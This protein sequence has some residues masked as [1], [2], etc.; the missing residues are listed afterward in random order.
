MSNRTR[1]RPCYQ[2]IPITFPSGSVQELS[3]EYSQ[4]FP[5]TRGRQ[6][7][8]RPLGTFAPERVQRHDF[9]ISSLL[10]SESN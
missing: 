8:S 2:E 10:Q 4:E 6:G 7:L 3:Q 5:Q 9:Q 1:F